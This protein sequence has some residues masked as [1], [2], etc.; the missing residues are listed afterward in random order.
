MPGHVDLV[1]AAEPLDLWHATATRTDALI[2]GGTA[3]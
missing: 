1:F 3:N 2:A